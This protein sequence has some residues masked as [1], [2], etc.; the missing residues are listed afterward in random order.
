MTQ[1]HAFPPYFFNTH[2]NIT[3]PSALWSSNFSLSSR[4]PCQKPACIPLFPVYTTWPT[5]LI[6]LHFK[7]QII[8]GEEY[9]SQSSSSCNFLQSPVT[10]SLLDPHT[11]LSTQTFNTLSLRPSLHVNLFAQ[12]I[13]KLHSISSMYEGNSIR[14]L[15]IMIEKN[16]MEIMTYKQHLFF[17]IISIQI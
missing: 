4:F 8:L 15:Q 2:F 12:N 6:L 11:F 5:H 3:F 9:V 17:N 10:L 16:R 14:K 7:A 13:T 1:A